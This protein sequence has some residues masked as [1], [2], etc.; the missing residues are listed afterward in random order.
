M[1]TPLDTSGIDRI[2]VRIATDAAREAIRWAHVTFGDR[3]VVL[4]SMQE[5]TLVELAMRVDRSIPIAFLDNGH[6]FAETLDTVRRVEQRYGIEVERVGP[7][8]PVRHDLR[9]GE[10][11]DLKPALLETALADR[12]AWLSGIR[13]SQTAHRSAAPIVERDR[14]GKVK[15]NPI[16][17][18]ND[19]EHR[20]FVA[21][22]EVIRNPLLDQDYTSIGCRTCTERPSDIVN[23]RSGRWVDSDREECGLH[24]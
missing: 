20:R 4:S 16:V 19:D 3:M 21:E 14:R 23:L 1:E 18:W 2:N 6:H 12:D 5:T 22:Y 11:C 15:V 13:R 17:Q 9:S 10:C 8:S 24:L 7:L